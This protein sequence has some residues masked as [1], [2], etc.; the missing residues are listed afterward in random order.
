MDAEAAR[1]A[2]ALKSETK[3]IEEEKQK[4]LESINRNRKFPS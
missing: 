1:R 2:S 4:V 3:A